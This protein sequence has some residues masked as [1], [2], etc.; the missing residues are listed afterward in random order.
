MSISRCRHWCCRKCQT[1]HGKKDL[2]EIIRRAG[3]RDE[4]DL[5]GRLRCSKC[6]ELHSMLL[7]YRS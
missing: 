6:G 3:R 2:M 1:I 5:R 4:N 7:L